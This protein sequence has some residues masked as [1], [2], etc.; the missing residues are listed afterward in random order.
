MQ[1]AQIT[2]VCSL[3][4]G[5]QFN[6]FQGTADETVDEIL[7]DV[8]LCTFQDRVQPFPCASCCDEA[9]CEAEG[10]RGAMMEAATA[11]VAVHAVQGMAEHFFRGLGRSK[12]LFDLVCCSPPLCGQSHIDISSWEM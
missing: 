7:V 4:G 2:E 9:L 1:Q 10:R 6:A 11:E 3:C 8:A 12:P 5:W